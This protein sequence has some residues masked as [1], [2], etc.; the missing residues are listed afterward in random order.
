[1]DRG[2]WWATAHAVAKEILQDKNIQGKFSASKYSN[3]SGYE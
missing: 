2:A 1:M 3:Y